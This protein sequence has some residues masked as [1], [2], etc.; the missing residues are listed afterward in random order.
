M[1]WKLQCFKAQSNVNDHER[2]WAS[3]KKGAPCAFHQGSG[4]NWTLLLTSFNTLKLK[5]TSR[6]L[7]AF[8]HCLSSRCFLEIKRI[9]AGLPVKIDE[10]KIQLEL[11]LQ[12]EVNYKRLVNLRRCGLAVWPASCQNGW[13]VWLTVGKHG[14]SVQ[15]AC[16]PLCED[17]QCVSVCVAYAWPSRLSSR[18]SSALVFFS[19]CETVVE[20]LEDDIISL[21]SQDVK[22]VHEELCNRVSGTTASSHIL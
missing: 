2:S 9:T 15:T 13:T 7:F 18:L 11:A 21:F 14:H 22:H 12:A 16:S 5:F 20:E 3:F 19:Q 17:S 10:T 1:T 4:F 8:T 6:V